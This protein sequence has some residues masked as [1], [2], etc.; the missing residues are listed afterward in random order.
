MATF[1]RNGIQYVRLEGK[2]SGK[3]EDVVTKFV[4]DPN[5]A[6]FF[7]VSSTSVAPSRQH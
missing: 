1:A 4:Q 5:V 7:L 6:V 3:K 2:G